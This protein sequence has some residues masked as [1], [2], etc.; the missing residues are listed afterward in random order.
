MCIPQPDHKDL[1]LGVPPDRPSSREDTR[2]NG[3]GTKIV[4]QDGAGRACGCNQ[5]GGLEDAGGWGQGEELEGL[6]IICPGPTTPI[7]PLSS[8]AEQISGI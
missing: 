3:E 7:I 5:D 4:R 6:V 1:P 8:L 2:D